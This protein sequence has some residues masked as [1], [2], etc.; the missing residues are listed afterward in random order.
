MK[1][2]LFVVA[3]LALLVAACVPE[4][5]T[6]DV[7]GF[8][9]ADGRVYA[10]LTN[11]TDE[12]VDLE[13]AW[14]LGVL[15]AGETALGYLEVE[16]GEGLDPWCPPPPEVE[17]PVAIPKMWLL[18]GPY[19]ERKEPGVGY[20]GHTCILISE[21]HPAVE[22]QNAKC[23]PINDPT[24]TATNAPCAGPVYEDGSDEGLWACDAQMRAEGAGRLP[25]HDADGPDLMEVYQQ[26]LSNIGDE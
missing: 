10:N 22:W 21:S 19:V 18:T 16:D 1:K 23:F 9:E 2:L 8:C 12:D 3:A 13:G 14:G 17:L 20:S 26:H 6:G 25:L 15:G 7:L 4:G 5:V 24:W 11:T